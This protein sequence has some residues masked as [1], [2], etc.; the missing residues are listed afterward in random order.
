VERHFSNPSLE[1][2]LRDRLYSLPL[3]E[4]EIALETELETAESPGTEVPVPDYPGIGDLAAALA[5]DR[6]PDSPLGCPSW[7]IFGSTFVTIL[8]A[9]LGDKTQ[10]STLLITAESHA[11]WI[12]FAGAATALISTSLLGVLVGCWLSR[13]ISPRTLDTSGGITLALL[14]VWLLWDVL[15]G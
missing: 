15:K 10:V 14:S 2:E 11:P 7:K 8:L 13:R 3:T 5:S 4:L 12:V 9:E 1:L 6:Q